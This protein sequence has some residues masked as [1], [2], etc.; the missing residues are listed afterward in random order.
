M[1]VHTHSC[2]CCA[3]D[4][5]QEGDSHDTDIWCLQN[6]PLDACP[7]LALR[8]KHSTFYSLLDFVTFFLY[9]VITLLW[10]R[11]KTAHNYMQVD[12]K[13]IPVKKDIFL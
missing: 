2:C 7:N 11:F 8:F 10:L 3:A 5:D 12:L 9:N 1:V 4:G 13:S 6:I